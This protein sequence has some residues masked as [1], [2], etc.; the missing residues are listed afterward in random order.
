MSKKAK[1]Y[2]HW[3]L[4]YDKADILW[5]HLDAADSSVNLL[6]AQVFE[7]LNLILNDLATDLPTGVVILS[8]KKDSFIY[9]ADI[10]EFTTLE[11]KGQAAAFLKRG[12]SLMNK[13]EAL[14]RPTVSMIH[15]MCLGGGTEL[16]LACRYRVMSSEDYSKIGLPE[17]KLGIFPG[18][19]GTVRS[20]RRAGPLPALDMMLTGRMLT[21]RAAK[22]IG[23]IDEAVPLR[24]LKHAARRFIMEEPKARKPG[25]LQRLAN[26]KYLRPLVAKQIKKQVAKK[27]RPE[28]YP[29]PYRLIELWQ[30]YA[31]T[32][33]EMLRQEI[34]E[35]SQLATSKTARNLVRVFFL[36]EA[37][38][39]YGKQ[40]EYKA[41][42]VHVIGGGIMGGDIA[43]WCAI[44]G[45][46]VTV[47][48]QSPERLA[49][50]AQRAMQSF[51]KKFKKDRR[52]IVAAN[53]RLMMDHRGIGVAQADIV[54]EA[55]FEDVDVKQELYK[56]I[57]PRMKPGAI[58]ATN[59][60][61]IMLEDL[62]SAL[63]NPGR[64]V[65]LHFFNPVALMPLVEIIHGDNTDETILQQVAAFAR[66][67]GKL[68]LP[69][70]SSPGFLVNRILMPYLLEAVM[71]VDE[72]IAPESIDKAAT[73]FGMPMGPI[74]LAD[75]VGLDI[76]KNVASI[77]S[78]TM[79]V[80][81]PKNL[82]RIVKSGH[83]GKKTGSGFYQ[84]KKGKIQKNKKIQHGNLQVLQ[85]RLVLKLLNESVACVREG[86]VE[87]EDMIDAG[88]IFGTGFAPFRS[89]TMHHIQEVGVAGIIEKMQA[90][91]KHFGDRFKPDMYWQK[92][93]KK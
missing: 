7:E 40:V 21:A 25:L 36:Q 2:K 47:Q 13:L 74:E 22:K 43:A 86:I 15:G 23:L 55:I 84:Y 19:G 57:E 5:L 77:L 73:D 93:M 32:P 41:K 53:D 39:K 12:H 16:S 58:L 37:L 28:H 64:L 79:N 50:T 69:V 18:Y 52:A 82:E 66:D 76:C 1:T 70:K 83:L 65:G 78:K 56:G 87:N 75:T 88:V 42:H 3:K 35:V 11:N 61:S 38:K 20:I 85:D 45:Y 54:I 81:L 72:G 90:F 9:G 24:Q 14:P 27:A 8:D 68:P 67:I 92:L 33:G 29:A 34:N 89:G 80:E 10:K 62:A 4:E 63:E 71:M 31:D 91:E 51:K 44:R 17:I 30:N 59:T 6:S 26:H 60:S 48:D 46:S 49:K